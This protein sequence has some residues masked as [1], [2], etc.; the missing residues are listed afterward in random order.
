[1]TKYLRSLGIAAILSLIA[2]GS[3]NAGTPYENRVKTMKQAGA[4]LGALGKVAKGEAECTPALVGNAEALVQLSKGYL[5]LF[6]KDSGGGKSRAKAE[7][8]SDWAGVEEKIKALQ[9]AAL[10]LPA[11]AKSCDSAKIGAAVKATGSAC[12]SCHKAY[13]APKKK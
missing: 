10:G 8:W 5:L 12:G 6:P 7:I 2:C 1:M 13:R 11:A 3:V 4:N 9:A